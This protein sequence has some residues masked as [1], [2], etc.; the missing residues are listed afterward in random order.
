MVSVT[1][2]FF[3]PSLTTISSAF[4]LSNNVAGVT[5]LAIGNAAPDLFAAFAASAN[6]SPAL[7]LSAVL[8]GTACVVTIV[9]GVV[10]MVADV[11]V[12]TV[13]FLRDVLMLVASVVLLLLALLHGAFDWWIAGGFVLLY[14]SY[15][16]CV[17]VVRYLYHRYAKKKR[18]QIGVVDDDDLDVEMN[19]D[20]DIELGE[21]GDLDDIDVDEVL[22]LSNI[23]S[24]SGAPSQEEDLSALANK[25]RAENLKEELEQLGPWIWARIAWKERSIQGK[26]SFIL[27][28]W[29]YLLENITIPQTTEEKWAKPFAVLQP[30]FGSLLVMLAYDFFNAGIPVGSMIIPFWPLVMT[31]VVLLSVLILISTSLTKPPPYFKLYVFF[32]F[33][34][35]G[36]WLY[37]AAVELVCILRALGRIYGVS[38][39]M[40]GLSAIA[41]GNTVVDLVANVMVA[42]RAF[43]TMAFSACFGAPT[44]NI[45]FGLGISFSYVI[46]RDGWT[47]VVVDLTKV[48]VTTF[49]GCFVALAATLLVVPLSGFRSPAKYGIAL[50]AIYMAYFAVAMVVELGYADR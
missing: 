6:G 33:V 40:I 30:I 26:V 8:G 23:R 32:G 2:E 13:P 27:L 43:A 47:P 20:G 16:V 49:V 24:W 15:I 31:L 11:H 19:E 12:R 46:L 25:T 45:L 18:E 28:S 34:M 22:L 39:E 37:V 36:V 10:S 44:F 21:M 41:W 38:E 48:L 9:L 14:V 50:L 29:L 35:S 3:C 5:F 7:A 42:K 4:N 17:F 1:D